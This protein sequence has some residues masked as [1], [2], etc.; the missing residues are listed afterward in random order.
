M[1]P[2]GGGI[3]SKVW[4]IGDVSPFW[5]GILIGYSENK[6]TAQ[7]LL[8]VNEAQA[9]VLVPRPPADSKQQGKTY[10]ETTGKESIRSISHLLR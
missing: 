7:Y 9:A 6:S 10:R 2:G 1:F 4:V 3:T 8:L 5:I